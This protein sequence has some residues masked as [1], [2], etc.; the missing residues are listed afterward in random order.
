M[1]RHGF[2][3]IRP[4][5]KGKGSVEDGVSFLQGM[6]IVISP[7][8]PN[9]EREFRSYAYKTDKQTGAILPVVEDKNNHLIDALRYAVEGL[10]RKGKLIPQGQA[11]PKRRRRYDD[12]DDDGETSWRVG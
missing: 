6:D 9:V 1:R 12:D 5:K 8:C 2:H 4:A 7:A 3:R 10:H 11:E